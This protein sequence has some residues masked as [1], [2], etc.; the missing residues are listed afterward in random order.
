M[1]RKEDFQDCQTFQK[2]GQ[3]FF[4]GFPPLLKSSEHVTCVIQLFNVEVKLYT[5]FQFIDFLFIK[6]TTKSDKKVM[7]LNLFLHLF[8]SA[9]RNEIIKKAMIIYQIDKIGII[10]FL[11]HFEVYVLLEF[12]FCTFYTI[13]S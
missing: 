3:N 10:F 13:I 11:S 8:F 2:D 7:P 6:F 4:C 5:S 9:S 12:F 1:F